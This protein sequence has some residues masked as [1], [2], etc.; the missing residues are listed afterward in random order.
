MIQ[1]TTDVLQNG[2][3]LALCQRGKQAFQ[4]QLD[5][6]YEH[7]PWIAERAWAHQPFESLDALHAALVVVVKQASRDEQLGLIR[8]HPELAGKEA[9]AGALTAASTAEQ[10]GAGLNECTRE[11]LQRLR[12]RAKFGFPF[13][14]AV[15]GLTR[16]QIM[17]AMQARTANSLEIEFQ[18]CLEQIYKIARFRLDAL[19]Q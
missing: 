3:I 13:V 18:A 12:Y 14:I 16:T 6:I 17:E 8:A 15:K 19:F 7:S 5:G 10:R 1:S 4:A 11:E 2:K 9:E